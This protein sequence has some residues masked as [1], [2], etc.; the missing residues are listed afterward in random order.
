MQ[1]SMWFLFFI[2]SGNKTAPEI[3][4]CVVVGYCGD[5]PLFSKAATQAGPAQGVSSLRQDN[6][7]K[8]LQKTQAVSLLK[9]LQGEAQGQVK[10]QT[11]SLH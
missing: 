6:T 9:P 2:T 7:A 5:L 4:C 3:P 10:N 1:K 8:F 11:N